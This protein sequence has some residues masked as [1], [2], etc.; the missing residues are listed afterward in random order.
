MR[1]GMSSS[2]AAADAIKRI[3]KRY[4]S[5]SGAIIA[6]DKLGNHGAACHG[7]PTFPYSYRDANCTK[8]TL[9]QTPCI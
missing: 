3:V 5:F 6:I 4:P 7:F 8:A 9:V 2:E 1:N